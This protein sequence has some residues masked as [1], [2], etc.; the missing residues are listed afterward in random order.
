MKNSKGRSAIFTM[1]IGAIF[2]ASVFMSC[3]SS[4]K[5]K[6][7]DATT[8]VVD[9]SADLVKANE[10]YMAEVEAFKADAEMQIVENERKIAEYNANMKVKKSKE[11][12]AKVAELVKKTADLKQKI[13][14]F[15]AEDGKETW[16]E[17]KTE[18]NHDM[19]GIGKSLNDLTVQNTQK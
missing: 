7:D 6:L 11:L 2:S 13:A 5:E 19:E 4:P 3:N 14:D 10:A 17:F 15:K 9:A 1:A 8:E 12:K 16:A 18:F